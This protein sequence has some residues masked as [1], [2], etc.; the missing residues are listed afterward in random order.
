MRVM[1]RCGVSHAVLASCLAIELDTA[2]GNAATAAA[3]AAH[4][5]RLSGYLTLNPHQNPDAEAA[6]WAGDSRFVG[7]KLHP[8]LHEY[9][10]TGPGYRVVWELA[11]RTGWPVLT[12]TWT[13]S[14]Y[15]DP[16][17]VA[18][19]A[20][21]HPEVTFLLGHSGALPYGF[22]TAIELAER[23]PNLYLEICGSYFTSRDLERMVRRLGAHRV[24]YGSD[25]PFIDLRYSIGRVLYADLPLA[26]RVTVLGGAFAALLRKD[27]VT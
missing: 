10:I 12:H 23:H 26:D 9:P 19:V 5:G 4:P 6:R 1:D 16:G 15:D 3:V 25:F 20:E 22:D 14:A 17:M 13:G 18:A 8:S 2:A 24:V 7:I 21:R 11:A 27:D